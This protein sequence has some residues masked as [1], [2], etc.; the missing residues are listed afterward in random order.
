MPKFLRVR[1]ARAVNRRAMSEM[2]S[3]FTVLSMTVLGFVVAGQMSEADYDG[4][5]ERLAARMNPSLKN[6]DLL[7]PD[8]ARENYI[9][10][11]FTKPFE[12]Q[13]PVSGWEESGLLSEAAFFR[14]R[15]KR[16]REMLAGISGGGR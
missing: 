6:S 14:E 1:R 12:H 15:T 11:G 9:S 2:E 10:W 3:V 8:G 5:F 7:R 13:A 16:M 4:W